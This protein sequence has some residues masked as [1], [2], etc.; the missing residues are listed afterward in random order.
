M[1]VVK[2]SC[3]KAQSTIVL[4]YRLSDSV[5]REVRWFDFRERTGKVVQKAED[6]NLERGFDR[7][8]FPLESHL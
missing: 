1:P 2:A 7:P 4:G 6:A 3:G 8:R 5:R